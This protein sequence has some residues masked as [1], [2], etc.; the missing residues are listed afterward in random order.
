MER[1]VAY[2]EG[3]VLK[4]NKANAGKFWCWILSQSKLTDSL[5]LNSNYTLASYFQTYIALKRIH[6]NPVVQQNREIR[7]SSFFCPVK[8]SDPDV[9]ISNG[10][11]YF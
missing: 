7:Q 3:Y 6:Q 8:K 11:K 10:D 5:Q 1:C 2:Q 4:C 9:N